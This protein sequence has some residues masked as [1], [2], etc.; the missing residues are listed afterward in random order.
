MIQSNPPSRPLVAAYYFPNYHRDSRNEARYGQGWT[1]WDLLRS[2]LPRY[3]GHSQPKVPAWG[4]FDEAD[5]AWMA[6]Q[7]DLA[8][9]HA[10]D[11]FLFDWY[12]YDDAPLLERALRDGFL[13]A[14]NG[15]RLKFALMWANHD[16]MELFPARWLNRQ[17][18]IFTGRLDAAGFDRVAGRVVDDYFCRPNYLRVDGGPYF[19]IYEV[20]TFVSGLGGLDAAAAALDRLR[21]RAERAGCGRPHVNAVVWQLPILSSETGVADIA[22]ALRRLGV[23]SATSY[24]WVHHSSPNA[25]GFP[26]GSY[27]MA[28]EHNYAAWDHY[29]ATLP[30]PYYPNVSMG[31]DP[32][33]RTCQSDRFE[34]RGYPWT[35]VLEGNT[36]SAFAEALNRAKAFVAGA[37]RRAGTPLITLNAWNEWTEG[38]YLLPDTV[39]GNAYLE[40]IRDAFK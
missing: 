4:E 10:I 1:E 11:A 38:S 8:A 33:P 24:A 9:D 30:I 19:S 31:W 32:S 27:T 23:D 25:A 2:A 12:W 26:R 21:A 17:D 14:P 5:P 18:R 29:A 28:A 37:G 13:A 40:R 16:W 7:V 6:R 35:A 15:D 36:P 22:E 39:H 3:A 34:D 20:G